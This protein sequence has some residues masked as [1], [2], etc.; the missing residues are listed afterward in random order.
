ME[1]LCHDR[2]LAEVRPQ[3]NL[4]L[5]SLHRRDGLALQLG[6]LVLRHVLQLFLLQVHQLQHFHLVVLESVLLYL[7]SKA[8]EALEGRSINVQYL[9]ALLKCFPAKLAVLIGLLRRL[10]TVQNVLEGIKPSENR[11][12]VYFKLLELKQK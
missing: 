11:H 9:Q 2:K 8:V 10:H 1:L 6:W 5:K 12:L 3:R 4:L 7:V